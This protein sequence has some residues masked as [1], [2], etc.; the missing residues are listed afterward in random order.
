M[1]ILWRRQ[2]RSIWSKHFLPTENEKK[3]DMELSAFPMRK[4]VIK[5][6]LSIN[7]RARW[8][9]TASLIFRASTLMSASGWILHYP[10]ACLGWPLISPLSIILSVKVNGPQRPLSGLTMVPSVHLEHLNLK[11]AFSVFMHAEWIYIYIYYVYIMF[12]LISTN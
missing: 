10:F 9:V 11:S 1:G 5:T 8:R 4:R 6:H 2:Q 12:L 3:E 7:E